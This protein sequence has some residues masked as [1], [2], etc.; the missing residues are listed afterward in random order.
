MLRSVLF[1]C[2]KIAL[3]LGL[4]ASIIAAMLV[5][6]YA[7]DLPDFSQLSNYHPPS[8]TRIYAADGKLM[9]E[10]AK[11]H[12]VFVPISTI[13]PSLLEAFIAAEDKNF[14]EHPGIDAMG[15]VRAGIAN[16]FKLIQGKRME[17][18]STITQQVVRNFLL[19]SERSLARK[20]KEAILSYTISKAM[21]KNQILE[22]YLN[23]I[24]LGRGAYGV[25]AAAQVYFNKSVEEL[26]IA[27]SAYIA[28]L[29]KA[30]SNFNPE[31]NYD[32]AKGRRDYV[33]L[34]MAE[35]GYISPQAAREAIDS[36]ITIIKR[37]KTD[38]VTADYYAEKVREEII[39][40]FGS[41]FFYNGGLTVITSLNSKYQVQAEKSLR[42]GI[43]DYDLKHGL[44][45]VATKLK[46]EDWKKELNELAD[47]AA[48]LEY[49]LAVVLEAADVSIKVGL[50]NGTVA[51]IPL[52]EMKWAATNLKSAKTILKKGDVVVVEELEK[53]YG[54]RQIPAVNG[55]M[56]VM[57]PYTGQVLAMVGGYDFKTS[58]FDRA[59]QALRQPGSLAKTFVYL[60]AVE[61]GISPNAIFEDGPISLSQGPGMPAWRP[62]NFKGDFLGN[63]TMR[64]GLAKSRNLITVRVAQRIGIGA[65]AETIKRLGVN[66]NPPRFYSM[67]LGAIETKLDKMM[68]AYAA[69]A[70]GGELVKPQFIELIQDINGKVI[71][72]REAGSCKN[73]EVENIASTKLPEIILADYPRVIEPSAAYTINGMLQNVVEA[74]TAASAKKLGKVMGGK[75]GTT[76]LSKD[77]WFIGFVPSA[78][79]GTY[80]GF[81]SPKELGK[82]ESGT[83]V[84]L[85]VFIDFMS[86]AMKDVPSQ[87]FYFPESAKTPGAVKQIE[88]E[89]V[90]VFDP[91]DPFNHMP[92]DKPHQDEHGGG[93]GEVY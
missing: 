49:K 12:R 75:T 62:K 14:Y 9:E 52:S 72:R 40:K 34:R 20:V 71:Y 76:N 25:A 24:F 86:T 21:S 28:A 74:G 70:N 46:M 56:M 66:E 73:C 4:S 45:P 58:K 42:K 29:P 41:E 22:L 6:Y 61:R 80:I 60:A 32:R 50:K 84:A 36:P 68:S 15:V 13:P 55:A 23:Q 54:L 53:G 59:T 91:D 63:I 87:P 18:A 10:Y 8:V 83:T 11:E 43:R 1:F 82:R 85:P 27:E 89:D 65:V 77:A 26:T 78:V 47:P 69:M 81:D 31:K 35:D 64:E 5:Y 67:V 48:L 57:H 3:L 79:V 92:N 17:G 88:N 30:P 51:S 37:S 7:Q 33:I 38:T 39:A 90:E 19:S 44:R 16:I 2:I 93:G